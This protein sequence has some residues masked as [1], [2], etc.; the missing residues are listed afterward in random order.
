ME[1]IHSKCGH[2]MCALAVVGAPLPSLSAALQE[3]KRPKSRRKRTQLLSEAGEKG[4][5]WAHLARPEL[6]PD[7]SASGSVADTAAH[8]SLLARLCA[9]QPDPPWAL[10]VQ[11]AMCRD[12]AVAKMVVMHFGAFVPNVSWEGC[13]SSMA[14]GCQ[15]TGERREEVAKCKKSERSFVFLI[16]CRTSVFLFR[17][18]TV[19]LC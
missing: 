10:V 14:D 11:A 2:L 8:V 9:A 13:E 3:I 12:A 16:T 6:F 17:T 5:G 4:T 15:Q 19:D 7:R 18:C 1:E